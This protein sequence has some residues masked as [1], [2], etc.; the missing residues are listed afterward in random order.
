M[1]VLVLGFVFSTTRVYQQF[2]DLYVMENP[3][4]LKRITSCEVIEI[5]LTVARWVSGRFGVFSSGVC[6]A[7][8][9]IIGIVF[10]TGKV[11]KGA[12]VR[13]LEV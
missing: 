9:T 11:L 4:D 7:D 12:G 13:P 5:E 10:C 2:S 3:L 1:T 6:D 8:G